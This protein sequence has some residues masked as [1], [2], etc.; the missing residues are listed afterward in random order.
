MISIFPAKTFAFKP[1]LIF[2]MVDIFFTI[3]QYMYATKTGLAG[4]KLVHLYA[5][6]LLQLSMTVN[7]IVDFESLIQKN[8][9]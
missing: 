3:C 1:T 2:F 6:I 5:I 9:H 8:S 7:F 4:S